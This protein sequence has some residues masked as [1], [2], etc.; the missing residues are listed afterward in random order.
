MFFFFFGAWCYPIV[1]VKLDY[2]WGGSKMIESKL[3]IY[4]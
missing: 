1:G 3:S 4:L 2:W